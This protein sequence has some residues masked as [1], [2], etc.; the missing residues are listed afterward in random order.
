MLVFLQLAGVVTAARL[1]TVRRYAVVGIVLVVAV[2]TPS[3]DPY[4][5]GILSI[6]MYL[7]FEVSLLIGMLLTRSHSRGDQFT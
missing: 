1:R 6:P 4:S 7:F 3:G 2:I 5:L